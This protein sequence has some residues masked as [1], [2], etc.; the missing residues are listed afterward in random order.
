MK[1]L[2][3]NKFVVLIVC[4][5]I[6]SL[7]Y[8][9]AQK[10]IDSYVFNTNSDIVS[11]GADFSGDGKQNSKEDVSYNSNGEK[12]VASQNT[13]DGES[14]VSNEGAGQISAE[15]I[16]LVLED[17]SDPNEESGDS[18]GKAGDV[19][20]T[21]NTESMDS[22]N[23][24]S[25]VSELT[26]NKIY[27]YITGEVNV[28]GVVILDEGSRIADAINAAG[29]TTAK[30]NVTKVNLVYVLEDG[31]K[32][33]IPNNAEL[34]NNPNFEY[35][36]LN[37]GD[38]GK[39]DYRDDGSSGESYSDGWGSGSGSDSGSGSV[40]GSGSYK[41]YSVVNINT[42]TQTELESLPG[43]GPSLALKII[44]YR[45]ENGK[46]SSIEEIKSVSG[47]GDSKF[48]AL[49]RFIVV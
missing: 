25:N 28:P 40:S 27:V 45:K 42:A 18:E 4:V 31:M 9:V 39:N 1:K 2:R 3:K 13:S 34:K 24:D 33:N 12:D 46:F 14:G 7:V 11:G 26:K 41:K 38:G 44:N 15:E 35:I 49:K 8:F 17:V 37:S 36:T 6:V 32:V 22:E 30:A 19:N 43:I 21:E 5:I 10:A 29:G 20:R 16:N 48:E 23:N 47:I